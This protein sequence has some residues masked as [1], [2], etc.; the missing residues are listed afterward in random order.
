[1]ARDALAGIG[2]LVTPQSEQADPRQAK[3][4]AGG[5][6]FTTGRKERLHRFLILGTDGGTYYQRERELT[7]ENA[8]IVLEWIANDPIGLVD[9]IVAISL[10]GRAPRQNALIFALAAC[11]ALADQ[12][13]SVYARSYGCPAVLRTGT[14]LTLY[15]RYS[16][17]FGAW[18]RGLRRSVAD[19]YLGDPQK[20]AYQVCKYRKRNDWTH[21][22]LLRSAH[23]GM[24][25]AK[26]SPLQRTLF[27]WIS[28]RVGADSPAL[29]ELP[30]VQSF[31]RAQSATTVKQWVQ[32]IHDNPQV[33]WEMFPDEA[34]T[35]PE[36]WVALIEAGMPMT[37]LFRKLPVITR[38][39]L[40]K[41]FSAALHTVTGQ[42]MDQDRL[43]RARV[44]PV[45]ILLAARTYASGRS[46]D[47]KGAPWDP[48][49]QVIDAMNA[50]FY[51]A[52]GTVVPSGKRTLFG[53][54]V[55]GSMTG[56]ASGLSISC[57]EVAAAMALVSEKTEPRTAMYGF[58]ARRMIP[59]AI[60]AKQR[61]DD[62]MKVMQS[63]PWDSTDCALPMVTALKEG[64]EVDHFS[65]Y[66][67]NET[68]FGQIHPHQAL[69][70]YRKAT[71]ID[72]KLSVIGLTATDFTIADPADPGSMDVAGFD[73][74]VP[75]LLADFARGDL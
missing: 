8:Q 60:T 39:G 35:K 4:H 3:N 64:W 11:R 20:V 32:V 6:T 24:W 19:W 1:M 16:T 75:Q 53:I 58:G 12:E 73:S 38:L 34:Q 29:A 42:L 37:A 15:V 70:Q 66:T 2:T 18:S 30:I 61:L 7:R 63:Q 52:F 41:P 45:S 55:S 50:A 49:G 26:A 69:Q 25:E 65:I 22:D 27:D 14:Q 23:P 47:G 62:V 21:R 72:A 17:Q 28:G 46:V 43:L 54:D 67:D 9:E 31:V 71:G 40:F 44:H 5:W 33:S 74:N 56:A 51:L 10:A 57:R 68:W 48:A 36:V 13:G 59:L